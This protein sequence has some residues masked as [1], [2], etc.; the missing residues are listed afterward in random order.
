MAVPKGAKASLVK[1]S[2]VI[3]RVGL[4]VRMGAMML[5]F[6]GV[7]ALANCVVGKGP[8]NSMARTSLAEDE[9]RAMLGCDVFFPC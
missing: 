1:G 5:G 8:L 9:L 2:G 4:E 7:E 3:R 6:E